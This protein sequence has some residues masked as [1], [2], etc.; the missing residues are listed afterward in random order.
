MDNRRELLGEML[1]SGWPVLAGLGVSGAT[2][3]AGAGS[4]WPL[5]VGVILGGVTATRRMVVLR[6]RSKR[7]RS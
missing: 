6:E 5:R 1:R 7:P 4:D 3:L 2:Y